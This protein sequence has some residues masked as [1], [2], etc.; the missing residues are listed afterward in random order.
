M[1]GTDVVLLLTGRAGGLGAA[2][3]G[4]RWVGA[5]VGV[6]TTGAE[7]V[8]ATGGEDAAETV[9]VGSAGGA[10]IEAAG[11][12]LMSLLETSLGVKIRVG[13]FGGATDARRT[14]FEAMGSSML[15]SSVC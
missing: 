8:A 9:G 14:S 1:E 3:G 11:G 6:S 12:A 4:G 15:L 2:A 5:T 7:G 13:A 10:D